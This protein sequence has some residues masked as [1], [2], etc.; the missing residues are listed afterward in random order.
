MSLKISFKTLKKVVR[1]YPLWQEVFIPKRMIRSRRRSPTLCY[2]V[3][4]GLRKISFGGIFVCTT[5]ISPGPKSYN[6]FRRC[7]SFPSL[8]LFWTTLLKFNLR[9]LLERQKLYVRLSSVSLFTST[10]PVICVYVGDRGGW[11][12]PSFSS[13]SRRRS[14]E[15][16]V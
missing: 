6:L 14:C 3:Q 15:S 13:L 8:I 1:S 7:F 16:W 4:N 12:F 5:S 9:S 2:C 11:L 10:C